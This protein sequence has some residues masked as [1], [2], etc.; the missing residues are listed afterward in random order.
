MA[1]YCMSDIHGEYDKYIKMLDCINLGSEDT[2]YVLGDVVDRGPNSMAVLLD[3][4]RRPNV[5]PLIGNHE[6]MAI[7]CLTWL[8]EE[9]TESS[10]E[11]F[12]AERMA[13]LLDWIN[14]GG[15]ATIDDFRRLDADE[16]KDI[17]DYIGEF[18]SYAEL[19]CAGKEYVL[20]HAGINGFSPE[21]PMDE[22]SLEDLIFFAPDYSE[23]Y[24]EDKF[25]VTGHLPTWLIDDNDRP[26]KIYRKHN[27][28][29]ID[30]GCSIDGVLGAICLDT[31]EEFYV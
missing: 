9:I 6:Y 26:G 10:L 22:Y 14:V 24:F 11:C 5:I 1:I 16:Q 27:H 20:V 25:L 2:L 15:Q 29:A 4:M 3:M 18:E 19:T 7:Q 12:D 31:G 28:I 8:S 23:V 21:I 13:A 17:R 30:C